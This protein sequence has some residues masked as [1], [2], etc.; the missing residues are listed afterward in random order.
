MPAKTVTITHE[1]WCND[2]DSAQDFETCA[3]KPVDLSDRL[4]LWAGQNEDATEPTVHLDNG[5][6]IELTAKQA[7]ALAESI[8]EDGDRLAYSL[9]K[10]AAGLHGER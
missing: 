6:G 1:P 9:S 5:T 10:V 2:H 3:T 7:S 8:R 4:S